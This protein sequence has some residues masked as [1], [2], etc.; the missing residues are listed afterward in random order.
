M[1]ILEARNSRIYFCVY[2]F[3]CM[4]QNDAR[5][6]GFQRIL[7]KMFASPKCVRLTKLKVPGLSQQV[8]LSF[9]LSFFFYLFIF[10]FL[11]TPTTHTHDPHPRPTTFTHDPRP[12]TFS[13]TLDVH[14]HTFIFVLNGTLRML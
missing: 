4:N 7:T 2:S 13:Y 14:F 11:P 6:I 1:P 9:F 12:T 10:L 8:V 5:F 3:I